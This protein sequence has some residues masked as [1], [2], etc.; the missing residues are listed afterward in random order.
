MK[1]RFDI[2][3]TSKMEVIGVYGLEIAVTKTQRLY[4][5]VFGWKTTMP[6]SFA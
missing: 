5:W 1:E 2:R 3:I 4:E 6:R